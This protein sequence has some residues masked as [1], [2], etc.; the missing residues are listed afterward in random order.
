MAW[1]PVGPDSPRPKDCR[2]SGYRRH[3]WLHPR[4]PLQRLHR[5]Q[6]RRVW[7]ESSGE[8]LTQFFHN[9]KKKISFIEI[10]MFLQVLFNRGYFFACFSLTGTP[11][12]KGSE[13]STRIQP[14]PCTPQPWPE[15]FSPSIGSFSRGLAPTTR[16]STSGEGKISNSP[17]K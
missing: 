13:L 11:C 10:Q 7:L 14:R 6:R 15:V 9:L 3:R 12:R 17:S 5:C 2:M 8:F 4:V 1:T 16:A